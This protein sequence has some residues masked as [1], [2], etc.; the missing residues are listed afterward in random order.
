MSERTK[1]VRHGQLG[2]EVRLGADG[3]W[4]VHMEGDD[5]GEFA[6][7]ESTDCELCMEAINDV[8]ADEL[9]DDDG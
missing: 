5:P 2:H 8:E 3:V 7:F 4:R 9:E 1:T 6:L